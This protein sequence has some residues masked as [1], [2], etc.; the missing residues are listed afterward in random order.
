M[1][2]A[3]DALKTAFAVLVFVIAITLAFSVFAQARATSD[4]IFMM[5]DKD[6]DY[7]EDIGLEDLT[8]IANNT[9]ENR[10]VGLE[11]IIPSIYRYEKEHYGITIKD[12]SGNIIARFDVESE[13]IINQW[14]QIRKEYTKATNAEK[15]STSYYKYKKYL[16]TNLGFNLDLNS[17]SEASDEQFTNLYKL[18]K[19]GDVPYGA[20]W[21][22]YQMQTIQRIDADMNGQTVVFQNGAKEYKGKNL[23]S[24]YEKAKFKEEFK[25]I[26]TTGITY[27]DE[28]EEIVITPGTTKLEIIY[29]MQ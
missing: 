22:G 9:T 23:Q 3:L 24:K 12:K 2:N 13:S 20:P 17:S 8:F 28:E 15:E 11:T 25:T 18:S 10:I 7:R 6:K 19:Y 5:K 26:V 1:E 29:T 4:I 27:K 14:K 21:A 16:N